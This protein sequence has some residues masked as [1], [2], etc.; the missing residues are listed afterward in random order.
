MSTALPSEL[1]ALR[2]DWDRLATASGNVFLTWEFAAAWWRHFGAGR[3]PAF[4]V[5]RHDAEG[6]GRVAR[7]RGGSAVL[8]FDTITGIPTIGISIISKNTDTPD[9]PVA[10]S[11]P[12]DHFQLQYSAP[13]I[14]ISSSPAGGRL[15]V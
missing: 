3:E 7:T 11:A 1:E 5:V 10:C 14:G 8:N 4:G 6:A 12:S 15:V 2:E 9:M 13:M